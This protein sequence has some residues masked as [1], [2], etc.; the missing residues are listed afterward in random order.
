[1]SVKVNFSGNKTK[2]IRN[3]SALSVRYP[4][5]LFIFII[6]HMKH[7][8]NAPDQFK[9]KINYSLGYSITFLYP[10]DE[11]QKHLL[12]NHIRKLIPFEFESFEI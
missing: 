8:A 3:V 2:R 12:F 4:K 10:N 7:I 1:M 6:F 5:D 9:N 11:L